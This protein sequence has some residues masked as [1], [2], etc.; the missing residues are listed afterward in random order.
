MNLSRTEAEI[1]MMQGKKVAHD[2]FSSKEWLASDSTGRFYTD[3]SGKVFSRIEFWTDKY[4]DHWAT[5]WRI[6]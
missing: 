1:A 3:E 6:V 5:D 2:L 4:Q